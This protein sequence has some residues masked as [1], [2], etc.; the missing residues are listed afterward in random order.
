MNGEQTNLP[1]ISPNNAYKYN[2]FKKV[3]RNTLLFKCKVHRVLPFKEFLKEKE[4]KKESLHCGEI[5]KILLQPGDGRT[6]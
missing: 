2:S 4:E 3:K 5:R 1:W 6:T